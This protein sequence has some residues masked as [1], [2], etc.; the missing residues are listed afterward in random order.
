MNPGWRDGDRGVA[1][2]P[3][4]EAAI[5]CQ[6]GPVMEH[7]KERKPS[8]S[9]GAAGEDF[10]TLERRVPVRQGKWQMLPPGIKPS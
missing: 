4:V 10:A 6:F 3:E 8:S 5:W 7:I 2:T 9:R 1:V